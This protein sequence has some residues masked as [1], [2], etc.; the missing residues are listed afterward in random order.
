MILTVMDP[1][2][3]INPTKSKWKMSSDITET[4]KYA[5]TPSQMSKCMGYL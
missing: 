5:I 2:I 3:K 4:L 1:L